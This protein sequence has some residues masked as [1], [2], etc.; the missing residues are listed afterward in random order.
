MAL[1]MHANNTTV[2][3]LLMFPKNTAELFFAKNEMKLLMFA[4]NTA[5]LLLLK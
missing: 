5:A 4:S 3:A 2:M 1:L